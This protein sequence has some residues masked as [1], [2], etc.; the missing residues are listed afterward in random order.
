MK[1]ST[2][3]S[4]LNS[5]SKDEYTYGWYLARPHKQPESNIKSIFKFI[6]HVRVQ[7]A[8]DLEHG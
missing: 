6:N 8:L 5:V 2:P 7:A 3:G 4:P 1:Y